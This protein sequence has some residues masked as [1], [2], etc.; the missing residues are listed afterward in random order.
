MFLFFSMICSNNLKKINNRDY[1]K[2]LEALNI[3]EDLVI[4]SDTKSAVRK[5]T[6]R[7]TKQKRKRKLLRQKESS[8]TK[9]SNYLHR[10]PQTP[11][12]VS[13]PQRKTELS[14]R[15]KT[16]SLSTNE[17]KLLELKYMKGP[18]AYGSVKTLQK[19]TK[20][21]PSKIKLFLHGKNNQ[22][23]HKI[24]RKRFPT[25]K[26]IAYDINEIWSQE[27]AYLDRL[28]KENK[29]VKYLLVAVDCLSRYLRIEPSKS[30]CA[31][32]TAD[33]FKKIMKKAT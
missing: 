21:K 22:I 29:D 12:V 18:A 30:K 9:P 2:I 14:K 31:T 15:R 11:E 23:K 25:L 1:F 32:T 17:K 10:N 19:S 7:V 28:A 8:T 6:H 20:L 24:Y 16:G 27:L 26:V 33:A 5:R 13:K 3:K 4:N